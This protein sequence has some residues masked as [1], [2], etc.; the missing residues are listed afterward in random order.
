MIIFFVLLLSFTLR[1]AFLMFSVR[2]FSTFTSLCLPRSRISLTS[3]RS[4]FGFCYILIV[5]LEVNQLLLFCCLLLCLISGVPFSSL[6]EMHF[7]RFLLRLLP[8][9]HFVLDCVLPDYFFLLRE[10]FFG[11]LLGDSRFKLLSAILRSAISSRGSG[12][13]RS[14]SIA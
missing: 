2:I 14:V 11:C 3:Y 4:W 13:K 6:G 12:L 10:R 5:R 7:A 9:G 1:E 8:A